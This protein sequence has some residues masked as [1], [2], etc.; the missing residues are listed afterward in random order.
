M[1][2]HPV[3]VSSLRGGGG[4]GGCA[5]TDGGGSEAPESF[6]PACLATSA[7]CGAGNLVSAAW[8]LGFGSWPNEL[9]LEV[10]TRVLDIDR[11]RSRELMIDVKKGIW[12]LIAIINGL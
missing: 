8:G 11:R 10:R 5:A 4:R 2:E 1:S 3:V 6:L 12:L 9:V 7:F